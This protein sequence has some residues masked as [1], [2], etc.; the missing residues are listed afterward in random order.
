VANWFVGLSVPAGDWFA[1]LVADAPSTVRVFHPDDLHMTVAFLG[2]CG[3]DAARLAWAL[4]R[5]C[6]APAFEV[7]LAALKPMG[8]ARRPS[9][10][11]A[12]ISDG[13]A[14]A[15]ELIRSLRDDMIATVD[16]RPDSREPLPHITV[17]RPS[18]KVTAAEREAAVLWATQKPAID[19]TLKI[20][21]LALYTWSEDR[22]TRLFRVVASH[23]LQ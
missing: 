15:V 5:D 21:T 12:V 23:T 19:T 7:R 10:L 17:A 4:A 8:N 18:R 11:S 2:H 1:P 22:R 9:A 13:H 20:D 14:T 6:R 3:E 16:G